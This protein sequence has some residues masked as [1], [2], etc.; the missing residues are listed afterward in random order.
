[1]THR[2]QREKKY[3]WMGLSYEFKNLYVL[4]GLLLDNGVVLLLH[5]R[6]SSVFLCL[7]LCHRDLGAIPSPTTALLL[8]RAAKKKKEKKAFAETDRHY[9]N[10]RVQAPL[11]LSVC[12]SVH[13]LV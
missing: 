7:A 12:L 6:P 5:C 13:P 3:Y 10:D 2:I 4:F 8:Y 1:M 9:I 11:S